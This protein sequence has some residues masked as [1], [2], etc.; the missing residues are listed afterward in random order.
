MSM[1]SGDPLLCPLSCGFRKVFSF[2]Y[3][4]VSSDKSYI[5]AQYQGESSSKGD[6]RVFQR[7][8]EKNLIASHPCPR[9]SHFMT[10]SLG[11]TT[12]RNPTP[13]TNDCAFGENSR[14]GGTGINSGHLGYIFFRW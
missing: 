6:D 12:R 5:Q 3:G 11:N 2:R 7:A 14:Q 9:H 1:D 8:E 13:L 4:S 10:V